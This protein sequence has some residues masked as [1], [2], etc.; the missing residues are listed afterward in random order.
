M[1]YR[2]QILALAKNTP[3][4]PTQVAKAL[5]TNGIL[6]GAML[7]EMCSKGMLKTTTLKIGGS[8]LYI[9]PGNETQLLNYLN[10]L[11]EKDKRTAE[12]LQNE[13]IIRATETDPL[14][15]VSLS[16]IKD[17]SIP[18]TVKYHETQETFYKWFQITD[19]E[20]EDLIRKIIEPEQPKQ[21]PEKKKIKQQTIKQTQQT[22]LQP[23][24]QK[25]TENTQEPRQTIEKQQHAPTGDFWTKINQFFTQN[26]ITIQ[27][28]T[29]KKKTE[30]DLL[31]EVPTPVGKLTYY[32]KA[33][34][35]KKI[36]EADISAA[37]VNGQIKKL[38]TLILIDG[39]LNKQAQT[40]TE[41]IK[42]VTIK[43]I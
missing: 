43:Q 38:P 25:Q 4:L 20:A 29:T 15:R 1:E 6:A 22:P 40:I 5:N 19:K 27:E 36:T 32:C 34:S 21:E 31:I 13:K 26:N 24:L 3:L 17:Y 33:K 35:K 18:L 10:N 23:E 11:N 7:S 16:Q 41:Q 8:P 42:G 37:Y 14:T 2:E 28:T 39:E 9:I 30:Y 12:K